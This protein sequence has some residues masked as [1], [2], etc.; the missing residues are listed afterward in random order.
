M[1]PDV[2]GGWNGWLVEANEGG[3]F[4]LDFLPSEMAAIMRALEPE[5][6]QAAKARQVEGARRGGKTAG[7]GRQKQPSG[8]LPQGYSGKARDQV[9]RYVGVSGRT[10]EQL[11]N[12]RERQRALARALRDQKK[13]QAEVAGILGVAQQTIDLWESRGSNTSDGNASPFDRR[14]KLSP[15]DYEAIYARV[16]AGEPH[17]PVAADYRVT[18]QRVD[19]IVQ[20]VEAR[21]RE[22]E[23]VE[24]PPGFPKKSSATSLG[25]WGVKR[26]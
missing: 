24:T 9:A 13:T 7:R 3:S 26:T 1:G 11:A 18:R 17:E 8:K 19:Q 20:L 25:E 6:R 23:P 16:Q 14:L 15:R 2:K 21:Q 4:T 12:V 5:E 22:P 10:L